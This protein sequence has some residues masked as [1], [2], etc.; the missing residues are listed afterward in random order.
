MSTNE[1]TIIL[2]CG[3]LVIGNTIA[4]VYGVYNFVKDY[5]KC[6]VKE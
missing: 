6:G 5:V 3:V 1:L 2:F 4:F